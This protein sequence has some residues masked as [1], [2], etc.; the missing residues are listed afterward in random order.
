MGLERGKNGVGTRAKTGFKWHKKRNLARFENL[1][2]RGTAV[3]QR[4]IFSS[5]F[6]PFTPFFDMFL[7]IFAEKG[8]KGHQKKEEWERKK[9]LLLV[10]FPFLFFPFPL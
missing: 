3:L 6:L 5:L 4:S 7:T 10:S 2:R 1:E 8:E 9:A